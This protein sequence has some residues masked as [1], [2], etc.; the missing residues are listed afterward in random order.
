MLRS[1]NILDIS[2]QTSVLG[3]FCCGRRLVSAPS[4][5]SNV[6]TVRFSVTT[7]GFGWSGCRRFAMRLS[8]WSCLSVTDFKKVFILASVAL[9][10]MA[11]SAS[12]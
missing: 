5:C 10:Q 9:G 3:K 4:I 8:S 12:L 11:M 1:E 7:V 2:P 6:G